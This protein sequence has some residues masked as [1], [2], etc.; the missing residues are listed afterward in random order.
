M[1]NEKL[2]QVAITPKFTGLEKDQNNPQSLNEEFES[3]QI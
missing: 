1:E 2:N 3:D